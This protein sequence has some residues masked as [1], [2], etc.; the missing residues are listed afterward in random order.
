MSKAPRETEQLQVLDLLERTGELAG[1]A[2][3]R[4]L[5]AGRGFLAH[6]VGLQRARA[7]R[8]KTVG[9]GVL[10]PL[11]DHH[12]DHLRDNVAGAL[13]D[14]GVADADIAAVAQGFAATADAL[15][16]VL[17]VQRGVLHHHAADADRLELRRRRERAGAADR[18]G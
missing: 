8:R 18:D 11:V 9:L 1:A 3:A 2:G 6:D 14:D 16:V 4:A 10:R 13:D 15:D 7:F 12:V 5:L 17:V